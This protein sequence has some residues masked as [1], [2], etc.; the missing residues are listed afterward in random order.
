M[1]M[2]LSLILRTSLSRSPALALT[3]IAA[4]AL[5]LS[6][7]PSTQALRQELNSSLKSG[8]SFEPLLK[9][10]NSRYGTLAVEPLLK[11]ASDSKLSDADRYVSI[12]GAAKLGGREIAPRL[13]RLLKDPS[14]MIRNGTL[15]AL[16]A[17]GHPDTATGVLP[18][19]KDPALVVRSEAVEVIQRLKPAGASQALIEVL[20]DERNYHGGKAQWV[21]QKALQALTRIQ[22][23]E[24]APELAFLLSRDAD[25]ALQRLTIATLESLTGKKLKAGA[26]LS[27]QVRE[28]KAQL[29]NPKG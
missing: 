28:W 2:T 26:P 14:W 29:K 10:W 23:R 9:Q 11:L 18:L 21:P 7:V 24:Q 13:A 22:A 15:R 4:P 17:L 20:K 12:M 8:S 19:L 5:A 27:V 3:L 6:A 25:P 16:G 1:Q